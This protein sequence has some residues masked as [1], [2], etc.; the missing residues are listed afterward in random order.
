MVHN[1]FPR[2]SLRHQKVP[3]RATPIS[4]SAL[5]LIDLAPRALVLLISTHQAVLS[6]KRVAYHRD[7]ISWTT[8]A[9]GILTI[10]AADLANTTITGH[11]TN[12]WVMGAMI[13]WVAIILPGNRW[14]NPSVVPITGTHVSRESQIGPIVG[15][16]HVAAQQH[17]LIAWR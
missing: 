10:L 15:V 13:A 3:S 6:E 4:P 14:T 5:M 9:K 17:T 11:L 2:L 8:V 7:L 16:A 12:L 1:H